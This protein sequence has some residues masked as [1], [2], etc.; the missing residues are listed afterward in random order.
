[1]GNVKR[2]EYRTMNIKTNNKPRPIIYG[3]ELTNKEKE[4]YDFLEDIEDHT[5]F[6]YKGYLYLLS[7]F[8]RIDQ[9]H[10]SFTGW[11]GHSSDSFLVVY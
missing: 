5:F 1:M 2:L 4:D 3:F 6:R 7:D 9:N 10:T 11:H 8:M